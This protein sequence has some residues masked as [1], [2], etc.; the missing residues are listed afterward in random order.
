MRIIY[1]K[2][3]NQAL[4][5]GLYHLS[6]HG[7]SQDSRNGRVIV[8]SEPVVTIHTDPTARVLA[9]A[10]RDANPF[11]HLFEALWMLAG[12]NDVQVPKTFIGKFGQYSDDGTTLNGAYGFR[13]RR[14]FGYDQL[15]VIIEQL[16]HDPTTRRAV[17]QMWDASMETGDDI[18]FGDLERAARGSKD[19]PCNTA[20]YFDAI[21]GRLNMTVLCRSNDVIWGAYGAN[22]V[23]FSVLLEYMALRTG[24]PIGVMRQFSNNY[25]VY[26]STLAHG[27]FRSYADTVL[28][29]DVYLTSGMQGIRGNMVE[30][31]P[32]P[33]R[34]P[35][36]AEG[37]SWDDW[38]VENA[39]FMRAIE[40]YT[41]AGGGG[42]EYNPPL[43]Y[44]SD[45]A[46][47]FF[48]D[49]VEP[50]GD[51]WA[52]WKRKAWDAAHDSAAN[53]RAEDWRVA[54]QQFLR[55][56]EERANV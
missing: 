39:K 25:H 47:K 42:A 56:R 51:A 22:V 9:S 19:V 54:V 21:D 3:P 32:K 37:E 53:I 50:M 52:E 20:C 13:W 46:V 43:G 1:S 10:K 6:F 23:H 49:V 24:L 11:F 38:H 34:V 41:P 26:E 5:E 15:E 45:G 29:D 2:S 33:R 16:R 30:R 4:H 35:L 44:F 17:L 14:H 48:S 12:R 7:I 28:S 40:A 18:V 31:S 55:V 27:E 36:L 8:S